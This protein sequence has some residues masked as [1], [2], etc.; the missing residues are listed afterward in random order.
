MRATI[1]VLSALF[2]GLLASAGIGEAKE[3]LFTVGNSTKNIFCNPLEII[4]L[5]NGQQ[6]ANA[7]TPSPVIPNSPSQTVRLKADHCTQVRLKTICSGQVNFHTKGCFG[8]TV[9]IVSP[10]EMIY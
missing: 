3:Y 5:N 8:G 7:L 9:M 2:C 4:I 10:T 6:L 1:L